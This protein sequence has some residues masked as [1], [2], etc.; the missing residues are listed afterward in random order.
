MAKIGMKNLAYNRRRLCQLRR[1]NPNPAWKAVGQ[2][3]RSCCASRKTAPK[4]AA[5]HQTRRNNPAAD[6]LWSAS[7][8]ISRAV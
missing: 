6:G 1:I 4:W 5:H 8:C 7:G 2:R 3:R